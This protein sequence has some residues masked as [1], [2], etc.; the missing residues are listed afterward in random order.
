MPA[1]PI[2]QSVQVRECD[3]VKLIKPSLIITGPTDL[4]ADGRSRS[5]LQH[6]R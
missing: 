2:T 4:E 5:V 6:K 3:G 1:Q